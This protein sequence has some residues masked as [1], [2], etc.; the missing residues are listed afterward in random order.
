M[1]HPGQPAGSN[2]GHPQFSHL[3]GQNPIGQ[4]VQQRSLLPGCVASGAPVE[5]NT[6]QMAAEP[7]PAIG[8]GLVKSLAPEPPGERSQLRGHHQLGA[9]GRRQRLNETP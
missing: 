8:Q 9:T 2:V 7:S 6:A 3:S 5:L 4:A 1:L